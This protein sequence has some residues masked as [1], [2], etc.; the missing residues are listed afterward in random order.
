MKR[1]IYLII[2]ICVCIQLKA[3]DVIVV[4]RKDGSVQ[5]FL[6]GIYKADVHFWGSDTEDGPI[7]G[8]SQYL[9]P[10]SPSLGGG[11]KNVSAYVKNAQNEY[12]V[13]FLWDTNAPTDLPQQFCLSSHPQVDLEHCDTA[14]QTPESYTSVYDGSR[15]KYYSHCIVIG[16]QEAWRGTWIEKQGA[17]FN[18]IH[19]GYVQDTPLHHGQTYYYR[20]AA[21][22]PSLRSDGGHDTLT[23]YGPEYSF[24]IPDLM[25]ESDEVPTL[26]AKDGLV[27]PSLQAWELYRLAHFEADVE[28][29]DAEAFGKMWMQWLQTPQGQTLDTSTAVPHVFDDG[30][31][32]F[33]PD[34]PEA[35]HEWVMSREIVITNLTGTRPTTIFVTNQWKPQC[36][37]SLVTTEREDWPLPL[38]TYIKATP[39]AYTSTTNYN[40]AIDFDTRGM[41]PG[42]TYRLTVTFAPEGELPQT[43]ENAWYYT[44]TRLQMG[45]YPDGESNKVEYL[46]NSEQ[47]NF[48]G[49]RYFLQSGTEPTTFTF[50]APTGAAPN[51]FFRI[52][53]VVRPPDLNSKVQINVLRVA[54]VRLTPVP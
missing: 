29:P 5:R 23:V 42:V 1:Y 46:I 44:P 45:F 31:I 21:H 3:Q 50:T 16:T 38:Q 52:S 41:M 25:V 34:V 39:I 48:M 8:V 2:F 28:L 35:F 6:H 13:V 32:F 36:E 40:S 7:E 15:L 37:W 22:I 27:Y 26:I 4:Q 20:I 18:D 12:L 17:D 47:S 30:T 33:L 54:E 49:T 14:F 53:T 24:R 11:W 9:F 51:R 10:Q 19:S 43:E